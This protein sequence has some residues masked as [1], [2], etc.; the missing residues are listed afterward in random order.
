MNGLRYAL[1]LALAF[2]TFRGFT[3]ARAQAPTAAD[4]ENVNG[5][6]LVELAAPDTGHTFV[7]FLTGDG[8]WADIDKRIGERLAERGLPVVGFNLRDY[9]KERRTPDEVSRDVARVIRT[10]EKK[11]NRDRVVVVGFSRGA[12][13]APFALSRLPEKM[14]SE[15]ALVAM[16]GLA[17]AANF[18]WHF[19]DLFRDVKRPDDVPTL[20]E[21]EKLSSMRMICV[22]GADEK[23]SGCRQ[24]PGIVK[25][26]ERTGGH[27]L[28]GD[29]RAVADMIVDALAR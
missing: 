9:L 28:D 18:K 6:P 13:L 4:S 7:V 22:Y 10:Y 19:Q 12:N 17:Q 20:P 26:V 23:E 29:F 3:A 1:L 24:V 5:L 8:G 14:R 11:W 21:I 16:I 15:V 27:H 2:T 25:R